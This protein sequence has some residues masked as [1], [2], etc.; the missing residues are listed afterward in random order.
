MLMQLEFIHI[1]AIILFILKIA[2][3]IW[4]RNSER[5]I[6]SALLNLHKLIALGTVALV[7]MIIRRIYLTNGADQIAVAMIILAGLLFLLAVITGGLVSLEKPL[8]FMKGIHKTM[9]FLTALFT[10][11]SIYLLL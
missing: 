3:G 4:L 5:P 1:A 8:P 2:S 10:L 7:V 9:P 11:L 6:S